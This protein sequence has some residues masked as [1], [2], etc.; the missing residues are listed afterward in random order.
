MPFR[1]KR[2]REI[3]LVHFPTP[4]HENMALLQS[5][6]E[7]MTMLASEEQD[8]VSTMS[9]EMAHLICWKFVVHGKHTKNFLNGKF[10]HSKWR[11]Q[12]YAAACLTVACKFTENL[13]SWQVQ[14]LRR[15]FSRNELRDT[16]I[17]IMQSLD[18]T[19]FAVQ[20]CT[21]SSILYSTGVMH[22]LTPKECEEVEGNIFKVY[23]NT[24]M[25]GR[26]FQDPKEW[27]LACLEA[28]SAGSPERVQ[29][30]RDC[31]QWHSCTKEALGMLRGQ[32]HS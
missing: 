10:F 24:E 11:K 21:I 22:D 16:E 31:L 1:Q 32:L 5:C 8:W 23:I 15:N 6:F 19:L 25:I 18:W 27:A 20:D 2:A 30:A 26:N 17:A 14:S 7:Y 4:T 28:S 12:L 9:F 3:P 29:I 13:Q